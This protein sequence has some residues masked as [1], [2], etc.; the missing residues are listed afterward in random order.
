[1]VSV[2][3]ILAYCRLDQE[4]SLESKPENKPA[5]EWPTRGSIEVKGFAY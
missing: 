2:E 4:A 3:R 1:M 5:D